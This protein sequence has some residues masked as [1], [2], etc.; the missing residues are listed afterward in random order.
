LIHRA[1]DAEEAVART[2]GIQVSMPSHETTRLELGPPCLQV[3]PGHSKA[4]VAVHIDPIEAAFLPLLGR[5][6]AVA[7]QKLHPLIPLSQHLAC[8]LLTLLLMR[9]VRRPIRLRHPRVDKRQGPAWPA[10]QYFAGKI[11]R[12]GPEQDAFA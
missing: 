2:E 8:T 3:R 1:F 7:L 10:S 12:F 9:T 6:F 5:L 4:V 11:S